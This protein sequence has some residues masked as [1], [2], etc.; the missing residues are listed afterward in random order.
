M[1]QKPNAQIVKPPNPLKR[2]L[3]GKLPKMDPAAI[4]RAEA[5]LKEL[6][7][8]FG[9]WIKD[10]VNKLDESFRSI[11]PANLSDDDRTKLYRSAHDLKGLGGTYGYPLVTAVAKLLCELIDALPGDQLLPELPLVQAHVGSLRAAIAQDIRDIDDPLAQQLLGELQNRV[12]AVR[13]A[14]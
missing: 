1:A 9:D 5:S 14:A 6:S 2:K 10:E 4:A 8:N 11:D 7:A 12:N 13:D 3:R